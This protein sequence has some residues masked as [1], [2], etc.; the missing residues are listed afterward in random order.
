MTRN[1][2]IK[3]LLLYCDEKAATTIANNYTDEEIEKDGQEIFDEIEEENHLYVS[4]E[5]YRNHGY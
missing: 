3:K 5:H 1:E 4:L 2:F